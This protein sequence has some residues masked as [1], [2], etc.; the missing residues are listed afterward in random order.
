VRLVTLEAVD[1]RNL[2]QARLEA[3]TRFVVLHGDNAQG[4]TNL[5]EA[6]GM[7]ATLR[8]FRE[9]RTARLIRQGSGVGRQP[10]EAVLRAEVRGMGGTRQLEWRRK[11]EK[12]SLSL[13]QAPVRRLRDWF[14]VLRAVIFSPDHARI[15]RGE[16]AERRSFLD[17]AAFTADPSHLELVRDYQRVLSQ[18]GA[19]LRGGRVDPIELATWNQRLVELGARL[20][21]RRLRVVEELRAHVVELHRAIGGGRAP[22]ELVLRGVGVEDPDRLPLHLE[23]ALAS[24]GGEERRRGLALVGPH[25]DDLDIRVEGRLARSFASQGQVRSLV[26]ALKLAEIRAA[27]DRGDE[28]PLFLLDDLT[29]ELDRGR[30]AR[31]VELLGSFDNQVWITTT[32]PGWLGPLPTGET[33]RWQVV[34]GSVRTG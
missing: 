3:F 1:W 19:L 17:R 4:K 34:E 6:V 28:P 25:K 11:G 8:S 15:I 31:L 13:D 26:L 29:S 30:M 24:A 27:A 23:R 18:K 21:L 33:T 7:L 9:A 20:T 12:R 16:P 2:R 32:E 5:L 14:A 22:V 10:G